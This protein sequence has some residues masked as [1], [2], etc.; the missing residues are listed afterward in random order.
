M[1]S[2]KV[3]LALLLCLS[4]AG[5]VNAHIII[6]DPKGGGPTSLTVPAYNNSGATLTAGDT[7]IWDINNS[8]GNDDF[9]VTTTTTADTQLVAGVVWPGDI[10]ANSSGAIVIWGIAR[11][12]ITS[13]NL[14]PGTP[15]C[16]SATAG[17]ATLCTDEDAAFA[18][19]TEPAS[20]SLANCF[21]GLLP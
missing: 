5:V 4:I 12:D 6:S 11:C 1:K 3:F 20:A 13:T 16:N 15:I 18:M 2:F 8:T 7:V 9:W 17:E 14:G 19:T 21:V 10:S